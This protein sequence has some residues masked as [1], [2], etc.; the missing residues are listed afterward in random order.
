M[1]VRIVWNSKSVSAYLR[2]DWR[3]VRHPPRS[4]CDD[5]GIPAAD[6]SRMTKS[7]FD[8]PE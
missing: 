8:R 5:L 6:F 4:P 1:F 2:H 7:L 3:S